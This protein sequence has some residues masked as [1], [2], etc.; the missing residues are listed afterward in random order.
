ME[1][2]EEKMV[3]EHPNKLR[4]GEKVEDASDIKSTMIQNGYT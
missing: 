3:H 2:K 1:E 4:T